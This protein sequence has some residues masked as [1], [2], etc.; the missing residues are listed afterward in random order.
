MESKYARVALVKTEFVDRGIEQTIELAGGLTGLEPGMVVLIKPNVNSND[1]FPATSNPET[2]VALVNY[3]KQYKPRQI[4]VGDASNASYL[5][6]V[7]SMRD[8]GIY[9]AA[10]E[11]GADVVGFEEGVW[12][13][14]APPGAKHWHQFKV[15]EVL[16]NADYVISQCVVKT[17]FLAGY[18]MALKNWMGVV[19]HRSRYSL[20]MS[21]RDL[22][23][24]R[25]AELNLARPADF[26]LLDGTWAMVTGGPFHG[27][28][29]NAN[30]MVATAN[31]TAADAVGLSILKYLG[32]TERI[33]NVSVW[34]QPVLRHGVEIGLGAKSGADIELICR[35][36]DDVDVLK[37]FLEIPKEPEER[38]KSA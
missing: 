30:L 16:L 8:L 19:D 32:T 33:E 12:V 9:Q 34:S 21:A 13:E 10:Q 20:H 23:Y 27:D 31:I 11:A 22:F 35:N 15:S 26:V 4:I 5:P 28:T 14:V 17:H 24:K 7:D 36:F 25:I 37:D 18:S 38:P 2:V 3:V 6:T 29:I 1:P